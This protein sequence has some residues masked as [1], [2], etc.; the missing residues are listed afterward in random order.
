MQALKS[1]K[2]IIISSIFIFIITIIN[3]LQRHGHLFEPQK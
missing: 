1:S 2:V 3:L